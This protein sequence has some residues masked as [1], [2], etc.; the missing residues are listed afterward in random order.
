MRSVGLDATANRTLNVLEDRSAQQ[1]A[2]WLRLKAQ[3]EEGVRALQSYRNFQRT[4][5]GATLEDWSDQMDLTGETVFDETYAGFKRLL[6]GAWRRDPM[7]NISH[8]ATPMQV[9][10]G[11]FLVHRLTCSCRRV[12]P[13]R[14]PR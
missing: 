8:G 6:V 9:A 1:E 12:A 7:Y 2:E 3:L 14:L 5:K 11:E 4:S 13:G 10:L